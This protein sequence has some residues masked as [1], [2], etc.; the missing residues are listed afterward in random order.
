MS[1][2]IR[3]IVK[4]GIAIGMAAGFVF[5]G[6]TLVSAELKAKANKEMEI[7]EWKNI[8]DST[9]TSTQGMCMDNKDNVY[10]AKINNDNLQ[11]QV[12]KITPKGK[13]SKVIHKINRLGHANDMTYCSANGYIYVATGGD[14]NINPKYDVLAFDPSKKDSDGSYKIVGKYKVPQ[15]SK[16]P[17]GISYD[18]KYN[19]FYIK[20]GRTVHVGNFKKGKFES[21]YHTTL[22][23][24]SHNKY[25]NQ[26]ITANDGK[27]YIPLWNGSGKNVIRAYKVTKKNDKSYVFK[28]DTVTS[29]NDS[30]FKADLYEIEGVDFSQSGQMH[31]ATNGNYRDSILKVSYNVLVGK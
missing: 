17:S 4:R 7:N 8:E 14:D 30:S 31:I 28:K 26:G 22:D 16:A 6:T 29:Y 21:S 18:A 11:V 19:V 20:K 10:V 25:I 5:L 9:Y 12:Y 2:N 23:Y 3:Q 13:K 15:F 27:I 24:A 1:F